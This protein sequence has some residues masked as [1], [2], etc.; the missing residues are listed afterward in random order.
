MNRSPENAAELSL[1]E[2]HNAIS[3]D[4]IDRR[5]FLRCMAWAGTGIVWTFAGGVPSSRLF[6]QA[7][8]AM[9]QSD[10]TFVQISD[11]HL[12]FNKAA[13]ADVTATLQAALN[14]IDAIPTAPDFL[15]HTGDLTH[16]SKPV[17]FDMLNQMLGSKRQVHYVPGEHDTS[18]DDGKSYLQRYGKGTKGHGWYSFDHKGVHFIG[19]VNVVQ[20]EGMG[21]L[22]KAQ[23]EWLAQDLR[24][25]RSSTPVVLFAH[26]P[27]WAIYPT[28][29]WGTSDS[30]QALALL[31][32]FGSVSVLNG[33][34][35]QVLQKVEGNA[36]FHT[37][38][39]TAFPQPAPGAAQ[40]PGPMKVPDEKLRDVL[41][42]TQVNFVAQT[43]SLA[44]VD[45]SLSGAPIALPETAAL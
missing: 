7:V 11:S 45:T 13:N 20:L 23:L 31:K 28:W 16:S 9:K 39:S 17:E 21:K 27:L 40:S 1:T 41:G 30:E 42:I 18:V 26:I 25:V 6:G 38:M 15:I 19:L 44:I 35:H 2:D 10:F 43:H 36:T 37:A 14:K 22:G 34:I 29:G 5:G 32:R 33:H 8:H 12:G 3:R 4:G 24:N